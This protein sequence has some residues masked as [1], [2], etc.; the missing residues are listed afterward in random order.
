MVTKEKARGFTLVELLVV[1]AIIGVL[2]A[3]LLPAIQAA[4]EAARRNSCQNKLKQIGL[5]LLNHENTYKKFPLLTWCTIATNASETGN[6]GATGLPNIYGSAPGNTNVPS[7]TSSPA[8]YSWIVKIMPA[9]EEAATYNLLSSASKRFSYPAFTQKGGKATGGPA[10]GPGVRYNNGGAAA[11]GGIWW[12]HFSTIDFDAVRCPSF[13]GDAIVPIGTIPGWD[14]CHYEQMPDKP[15]MNGPS[16]PWGVV[17]TNYKAM[18]ATHFGCLQQPAPNGPVLDPQYAERPNGVIVPPDNPSS[19]G[20]AVRAVVDGM[21][22]TIVVAE[23]K[24]QRFSSWF[25]GTASYVTAIPLGA[26]N[27]TSQ[28]AVTNKQA[29]QPKR[30]MS[31]AVGGSNIT[32]YFWQ[33]D[34][35]S[36]AQT[37]LNFGSK[38]EL[39]YYNLGGVFP[40]SSP[41]LTEWEYGPSS[42]HSGIILHAFGDAHVQGIDEAIDPTVYIQLCTK[43]GKEPTAVPE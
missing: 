33:F 13:S 38:N 41:A 34:P 32:T 6:P 15:T 22:K 3:L 23:S 9:L 11:T 1:I 14:A 5:A 25:D 4:R 39:R 27:L 36:G 35:N 17:T 43:A 18:A 8:G 37:A 10:N 26:S 30:V 20:T 16:A 28:M 21:S 19:Q 40:L 12:R 2:V 31:G 7:M 29:V 42:D 24:E